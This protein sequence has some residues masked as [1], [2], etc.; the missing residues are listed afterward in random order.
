MVGH[1]AAYFV[2]DLAEH[3]DGSWGVIEPNDASMGENDSHTLCSRP[4]EAVSGH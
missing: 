3:E 4:K 1:L 2:I